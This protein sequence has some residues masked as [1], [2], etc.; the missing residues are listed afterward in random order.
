M[1]KATKK[2][3]ITVLCFLVVASISISAFALTANFGGVSVNGT[4]TTNGTATA[5]KVGNS[6]LSV[7]RVVGIIISVG[8]LMILGIKYMMGSAEEKAEYKKTFVPYIIGA[9]ILFAAAVL[10]KTIYEFAANVTA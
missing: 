8:V 3:L 4:K 10:A 9:V 7:I 6:I 1:N 5:E 2:L